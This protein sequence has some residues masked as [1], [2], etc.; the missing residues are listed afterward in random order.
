L[1]LLEQEKLK[2]EIESKNRQLATKALLLSSHNELESVFK[3]KLS[4]ISRD[5]GLLLE[6]IL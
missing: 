6:D 3:V 4:T 1:N 2:S 5:S